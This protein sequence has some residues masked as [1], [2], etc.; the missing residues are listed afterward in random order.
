MCGALFY[1][2]ELEMM[3]VSIIKLNGMWVRTA[4]KYGFSTP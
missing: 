2:I 1:N 4:E 3:S